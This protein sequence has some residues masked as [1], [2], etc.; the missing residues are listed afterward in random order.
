MSKKVTHACLLA[1]LVA[2]IVWSG[3]QPK[4]RFTWVMEV[5]PA[6]IGGII[7]VGTYRRFQFSTLGYVLTW[8]FAIILAAGGHWTY[9]EVPLGN[10]ASDVFGFSRNHFD[11]LGHLFQGIVPA[12]LVRELLLRTSP[13]KPGKWLVFICISVALAVSAAYELFEWQYAVVFGGAQAESFLGSQGDPWDA[14]KDMFMAML[15]AMVSTILLG[16]WQD[17]QI[18]EI[19]NRPAA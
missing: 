18:A 6:V 1:T 10:W 8:M 5:F 9:A 15:G 16:K 14:Q 11:R 2:G 3:Y 4:E 13:L 7:L 17:R 19:N 12:M